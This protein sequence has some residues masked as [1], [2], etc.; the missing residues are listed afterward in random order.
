MGTSVSLKKKVYLCYSYSNSMYINSLCE[1][2]N[3]EGF[4]TITDGTELMPGEM[5]LSVSESI[6]K[7]DYFVL[8]ISDEFG[9]HMREEYHTALIYG[10]LQIK[11]NKIFLKKY[12]AGRVIWGMSS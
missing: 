3:K 2:I 12:L 8:I 4:Q 9:E 10:M 6:K 11:Y 5:I 1:K 7:C